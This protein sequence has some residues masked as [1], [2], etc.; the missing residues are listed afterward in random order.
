VAVA[1]RPRQDLTV[2]KPKLGVKE[3][4]FSERLKFE[5]A[6]FALS[7]KSMQLFFPRTIFPQFIDPFMNSS[8]DLFMLISF[9]SFGAQV[10]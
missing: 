4:H 5:P 1:N 8:N 7:L 10:N 6:F 2:L 3:R 9:L